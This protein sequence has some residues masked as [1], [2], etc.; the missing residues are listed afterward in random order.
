[1]SLH[2]PAHSTVKPNTSCR[3]YKRAELLQVAEYN[4]FS[5]TA[6]YSRS[7]RM[8]FSPPP[9]SV[10]LYKTISSVTLGTTLALSVSVAVYLEEPGDGGTIRVSDGLLHST[11]TL[12]VSV[13]STVPSMI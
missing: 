4:F 2:S 6:G 12:A 10:D 8:I 11:H 7:V 3:E 1:M 5:A 13:R 9:T